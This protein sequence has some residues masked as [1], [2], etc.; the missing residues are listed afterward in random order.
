MR[1]LSPRTQ[2]N[3]VVPVRPLSARAR[4]PRPSRSPDN[5][6]FVPP[7]FRHSLTSFLPLEPNSRPRSHRVAILVVISRARRRPVPVPVV[8]RI[9]KSGYLV[10]HEADTRAIPHVDCYDIPLQTDDAAIDSTRSDDWSPSLRRS[11]NRCCFSCS[12]CGRIT[13]K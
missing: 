4:P 8:I 11:R 7:G 10:S 3:L 12:R 2:H 6:E 1:R 9:L 13:M 5:R